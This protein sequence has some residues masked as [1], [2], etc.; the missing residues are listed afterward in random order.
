MK[1]VALFGI[2]IALVVVACAD[3][4]ITL[5]TISTTDGAVLPTRCTQPT[6]CPSGTFCER[7]S[8]GEAAGTC[9]LFPIDC[10]NDE[11]P[12]CGCD[13]II[14]FNDCLRRL[15]GAAAST[16]GVCKFENAV[17]CGGNQSTPCPTGT[18]CGRLPKGCPLNPVGEC[19]F[20][21]DTC[22][23]PGGGP[24]YNLCG[25][26]ADCRSTCEAIMGGGVYYRS[27]ACP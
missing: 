11:R 8:C 16:P 23:P 17:T 22:P 19:W 5:A 9:Q 10:T 20:L 18:V 13:G 7:T 26:G 24:K 3:E 2:G 27:M 4:T 15:N 25:G 21:P 12:V 1:Y 6:D 14:Y